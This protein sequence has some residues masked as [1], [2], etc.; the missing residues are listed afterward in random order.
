MQNLNRYEEA[1]KEY[2]EAILLNPNYAEAHA[3]LG[4][5][6]LQQG[7][8]DNA[9]KELEIAHELFLDQKRFNDANKVLKFLRF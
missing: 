1:E 2:R 7:K 4:G 8:I 6:Y 5:L 9:G 3:N